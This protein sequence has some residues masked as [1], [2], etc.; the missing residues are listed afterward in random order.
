MNNYLKPVRRFIITMITGLLVITGCLLCSVISDA[1]E[2]DTGITPDGK[3]EYQIIKEASGKNPGEA[4]IIDCNIKSGKFGNSI[5]FPNTITTKTKKKYNVV[6]IDGFTYPS[7][8][9]AFFIKLKV[10]QF[11]KTVRRLEDLPFTVR[12]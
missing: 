12:I 4:F 5:V 9:D 10:L 8:N 1:K 6:G 2:D 11:Q 3:F 7:E